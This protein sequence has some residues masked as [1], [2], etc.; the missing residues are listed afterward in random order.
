MVIDNYALLSDYQT[1]FFNS[2]STLVS[3]TVPLIIGMDMS[4]NT[5]IPMMDYVGS[6]SLKTNR[7]F[8]EYFKTLVR[9]K[10]G[11]DFAEAVFKWYSDPSR[12]QESVSIDVGDSNVDYVL[13]DA[14]LADDD[15]EDRNDGQDM[16][17]SD[18][19]APETHEKIFRKLLLDVKLVCPTVLLGKSMSLGWN[20]PL[21]M[22]RSSSLN[23]SH[24][25]RIVELFIA[26]KSGIL[27]EDTMASFRN[28]QVENT[29]F[30]PYYVNSLLVS[31]S[32]DTKTIVNE[33]YE[34][35]TCNL[36]QRKNLYAIAGLSE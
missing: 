2:G 5:S 35:D 22:I 17:E 6:Q 21:Y 36:L 31:E 16:D 24:F 4:I 9:F 19:V 34:K 27:A 18:I 3:N 1:A 14:T 10:F 7:S 28:V 33:N 15:D 11:G 26:S 32:N 23:G 20:A 12:L 8:A 13:E 29:Y 25:H 30:S